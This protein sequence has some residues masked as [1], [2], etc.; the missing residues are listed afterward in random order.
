MATVDKLKRELGEGTVQ[1]DLPCKRNAWSLRSERPH[2]TNPDGETVHSYS[3]LTVNA[4]GHPLMRNYHRQGSEKRMVLVLPNGAADSAS[5]REQSVHAAVSSGST[6]GQA[7][8][9]RAWLNAQEPSNAGIFGGNSSGHGLKSLIVKIRQK[10][11]NSVDSR[12]YITH[13]DPHL[14]AP[15]IIEAGCGVYN[16]LYTRSQVRSSHV[17]LFVNNLVSKFIQIFNCA[18][19]FVHTARSEV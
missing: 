17:P 11:L 4:D 9:L 19:K 12:I 1:L 5:V 3:M 6:T 10:P 8:A 14:F 18:P 16:V 13:L 2:R 15:T 7:Q